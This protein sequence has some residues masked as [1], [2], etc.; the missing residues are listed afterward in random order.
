MSRVKYEHIRFQAK[1]LQ[2][3]ELANSICEEYAQQGFA[4]TGR[5]LFYQLVSRGKVLNDPK[6]YKKLTERIRD[7]RLTGLVDWDHIVD[8]T[9]QVRI[10]NSYEHAGEVLEE[11]ARVYRRDPWEASGQEIRPEVWVEKDALIDVVEQACSPYQVPCMSTRGYSSVTTLREGA[12]R[13]KEN[14]DRGLRPVVF[15]LGD[16]DPSG[17]QIAEKIEERLEL[18]A[19]QPITLK[20]IGLTLDQVR[21]Y[22]PPPNDP[23]DSDTRTP[24]YV[25][26]FG[27]ECWELDA[28]EPRVI[29]NLIQD[30]LRECI[31][32]TDSWNQVKTEDEET[33]NQLLEFAGTF[34][35]G[36][37][38]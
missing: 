31:T 27:N 35:S 15:Y 38:Q 32:D 26:Q 3:I 14:L 18:F 2:T 34:K 30:H 8:R 11:S 16:H 28:L 20:R 23:K 6:E 17:L 13:V 4:L 25:A 1:T 10:P 12:L 7:G 29:I 21:K 19:G 33:R 37:H 22:G 36:G 5:Q 24:D 9:R